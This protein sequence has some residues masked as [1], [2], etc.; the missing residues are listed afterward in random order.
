MPA[1][2]QPASPV[3][4]TLSISIPLHESLLRQILKTAIDNPQGCLQWAQV[5]GH[6]DGVYLLD[7]KEWAAVVGTVPPSHRVDLYTVARG[8]HK[9][10][11]TRHNLPVATR[12]MVLRALFEQSEE[13]VLVL[14]PELCSAIIQ[15]ALFDQLVY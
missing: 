12:Q 3:H 11:E 14:L 15:L 5:V 4:S 13:T 6:E 10:F 2:I 7:E 1:F 9:V 8:L